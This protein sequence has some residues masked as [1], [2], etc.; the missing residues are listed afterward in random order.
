MS[1]QKL[2]ERFETLFNLSHLGSIAYVDQAVNMP[3]GGNAARSR[4]MATLNKL[5]HEMFTSSEVGE[6]IEAAKSESLGTW[7]SENLRLID[8]S[9]TLS[10]CLSPDFVEKRTKA[11][12]ECEHLWRQI[13]KDN[14]WAQFKPALNNILDLVKEEANIKSQFLG[15]SP[16]DSLLD[17]FEE[18]LNSARIDDIFNTVKPFLIDLIPIVIEKQEKEFKQ[19]DF[20]EVFS[21]EDQK[22]LG[23]EIV[24]DIGF[25]FNHGRLDVSHHPFCGGVPEDVRMT[26]RYNDDEFGSS[27]MGVIH[28]T[29]HAMYE[30]NL[31]KKYL[32]QPVGGSRGMAVHESQSLIMEMQACRSVEFIAY[33]LPKLKKRWALKGL[34]TVEDLTHLYLKVEPGYIRVDADELCYPLHIIM[35]Y[36]IEKQLISGEM[37]VDE[38]PEAWEHYMQ[39]FLGLST[40][41]NGEYDYK[42]G[43]MQDPHWAFGGFGYFPTYSLGAMTAAQLFQAAKKEDPSC[44]LGISTGNFQPLNT[45][46]NDNVRNFGSKKTFDQIMLDATGSKL[47]PVYFMDHLKRRYLS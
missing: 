4:A 46:L 3:P 2:T 31:P 37:S 35:R 22:S 11:S 39:E 23:L 41:K 38:I 13:R 9:Y 36:E 42:D 21:E 30:Q 25:D 5:K 27:L 19:F 7:E 44:S 6:W 28:E 24:K 16:Y 34:E 32:S 18:G 47:D 20:K 33:L 40:K 14:D 43:C 45:W 10:T 1:Y 26:T 8:K 17:K 15:V 12:M 29:G